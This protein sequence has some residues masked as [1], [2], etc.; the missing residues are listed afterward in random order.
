M[1]HRAF[2]RS[3]DPEVKARLFERNNL[4]GLLHLA[5]HMGLIVLTGLW[6]ALALP[7][8]WLFLPVHGLFLVFLFTLEHEATHKTPFETDA[9]NTWGGRASGLVILLPFT[10]FRYFHLAHHRYTN[11]PERDPELTFGGKPKGWRAYLHYVSGVQYWISMARTIRRL[12]IGKSFED[13]V[14]DRSQAVITRE[15]RLMCVVYGLAMLSLF[16]SPLVIWV[17]VL[18]MILGQPFLRLYLLA[19]HGRCPAVADMFLNTRTTYTNRAMRFL[20]W[21]MPFHIEHHSA[22]QVPFHKLA[23]LNRLT[24]RHL[25]STSTSY[26]AFHRE[27]VC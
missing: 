21:N 16:V 1:D 25:T 14:P 8:W 5:G 18:P 17:W 13:F 10:W 6:I 26:R 2:L 4:S 20:A 22:P 15:A 27:Y 24:E 11:D 3:L 23:E 19:E 7:F 9:L 12:A